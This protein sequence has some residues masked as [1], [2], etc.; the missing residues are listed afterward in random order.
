MEQQH[1]AAPHT[2]VLQKALAQEITIRTHS[3]E[4]FQKA[5][6]TSEFLFSSGDVSFLEQL[7]DE[8]ILEMFEGVPQFLI[9]K[10]DLLTEL[11]VLDLLSVN[12]G[13]FQSK[14]EARKMIQGG[15]VAVNRQKVTDDSVT[16]NCNSLVKNKY[17][18]VQKGKKNYFLLIAQ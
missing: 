6:K 17:I 12:S 18:I 3:E 13:V 4:D 7:S 11:S 9:K 16:F 8:E 10:D 14:G 15:G 5:V 1:L 2:R